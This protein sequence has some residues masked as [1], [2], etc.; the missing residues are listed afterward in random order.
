VKPVAG[1]DDGQF[2][3]WPRAFTQSELSGR[4]PAC[5]LARVNF[6]PGFRIAAAVYKQASGELVWSLPLTKTGELL[7]V[8]D[9]GEYRIA[10]YECDN[11][12]KYKEI[13]GLKAVSDSADV[14]SVSFP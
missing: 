1:E 5:F 3:G 9:E 2:P 6:D 14:V 4:K 8:Y 10:L 13:S 11:P 12:D 7:G